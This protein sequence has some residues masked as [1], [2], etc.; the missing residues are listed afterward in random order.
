MKITKETQQIIRNAVEI[1]TTLGV[2]SLVMDTFSLRGE[3]KELGIA[4][5]MPTKGME[6]EFD[7][8]GLG[9]TALLKSRLQ[10]LSDAQIEFDVINKDAEDKVVSNLRIISGRTKIGFKCHDPKLINAPKA[11]NDPVYYEMRLSAADVETVVKG[12]STMSSESVNFSTDDATL[13]VKISDVQ[14][15]MFSHELDTRVDIKDD[16]A[17]SLSKTYKSKTLRTIFTNYIRKDDSHALPISIT[18][19]GVMRISVLDMNIYLFP[20]R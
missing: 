7:A 6:L 12:I 13:F 18:R 8:I 17:G 16:A 4:I 1:A 20:E 19:R 3:N 10:M 11:I 15:D 2:E 14:G 9:R 5:I